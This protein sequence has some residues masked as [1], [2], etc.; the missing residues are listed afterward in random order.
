MFMKMKFILCIL[1]E[2][3]G[4]PNVLKIELK[5]WKYGTCNESY[6]VWAVNL[7]YD[8]GVWQ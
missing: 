6:Y 1:R 3:Q 8:Y 2:Q 4:N 5:G 7:S